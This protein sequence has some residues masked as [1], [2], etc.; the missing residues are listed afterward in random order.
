[1]ATT[2]AQAYRPPTAAAPVQARPVPRPLAVYRMAVNEIWAFLLRQPPS[3]W[4]ICTYLFFEYVR[5]QNIYGSLAGLP[6][7]LASIV[8]AGVSFMIEGGKWRNLNFTDGLLAAFSAVVLI[9]SVLAVM[10]SES[11]ANLKLYFSW[12]LIYFLITNIVNNRERFVVFLL[13][14]LMYCL[15]MSQHG[16]R[17]WA[18]AG[19]MFRTWGT[20]C[21]PGWFNNSG[22]CG[23]QM[24]IYF[25]V[26]LFFVLA[27]RVYWGRLKTAFFA[28]M[29]LSA[30]V[31]IMGSSS[32]GSLV[33][34]GAVGMWLIARSK[35]RVRAFVYIGVAAAAI[36]VF[37]PEGAKA[38]FD[39]MGDD[40]TSELRL[41]YWKDG[42]KIFEQHP[43][44]G[45]GYY[46]WLKYYRRNY[47]ADGEYPHNI[48]VQAG[49]EMGAA[50]LAAF[51]ALIAAT[52]VMN[53]RTRRLAKRLGDDR[54]LWN[55]ALGLDGAL[56]GF[57]VSGFFVTVLYYPFFWINLAMSQCLYSIAVQEG[58]DQ[59]AAL[60]AARWRP[61]PAIRAPAPPG[62]RLLP[63]L[64]AAPPSA[65]PGPA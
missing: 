33:G 63:A 10:P 25:S 13:A 49:A 59:E 56:I 61:R 1:M 5:P 54:L 15:K 37:L 26:S 43:L 39:T 47:M 16:A 53:R 40:K 23:I 7:A 35:H 45:I 27:L 42:V 65:A 41:Q 32:R 44:F 2:F 3:F 50:G 48:F 21:A 4:F 57:L 17:S 22:E 60:A 11:F 55:L 24:I 30:A 46:N 36:V 28:F 34:L 29:P 19:F 20:T 14:W 8:L 38:R 9:S 31:T 51:I 62:G 12:V 6:W 58:A 64:P 52:F 18:E